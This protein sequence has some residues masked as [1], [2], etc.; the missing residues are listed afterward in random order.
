MAT[1]FFRSASVPDSRWYFLN[2]S[3][4]I[5]STYVASIC[6]HFHKLLIRHSINI[7]V[8]R[9]VCGLFPLRFLNSSLK[10]SFLLCLCLMSACS[11]SHQLSH[12]LA[13]LQSLLHLAHVHGHRNLC[14]H[15]CFR[16][17]C[18]T[19]PISS[20]TVTITT[21]VSLSHRPCRSQIII[22]VLSPST[23]LV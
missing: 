15:F 10:Q 23:I 7:G 20:S 19:I 16:V 4:R 22:A 6:L 13:L 11:S 18:T 1:L 17:S 5:S 14:H 9:I 12:H 3:R 21:I 8:G 2:F